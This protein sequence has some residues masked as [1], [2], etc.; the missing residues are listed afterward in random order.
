M[1]YSQ[2]PSRYCARISRTD[3]GP[4]RAAGPADSSQAPL[5]PA[6]WK[7]AR[8]DRA[9]ESSG[10]AARR[11]PLVPAASRAASLPS[12]GW[13]SGSGPHKDG[14]EALKNL[15]RQRWPRRWSPAAPG[16][17]MDPC[18]GPPGLL[19]P[20]LHRSHTHDALR[21]P[22]LPLR[23]HTPG[24]QP[25]STAYGPRRPGLAGGAGPG[26]Q[27]SR[28]SA[29]SWP[30][31]APRGPPRPPSPGL[32]GGRGRAS[33]GAAGGWDAPAPQAPPPPAA[34]PAGPPAAHK[35]LGAAW[36]RG[37]TRG[38]LH[39]TGRTIVTDA[40]ALPS[41]AGRPAAPPPP[42]FPHHYA[43]APPPPPPP[44]PALPSGAASFP[45]PGASRAA[46]SLFPGSPRRRLRAK[47]SGIEGRHVC[48]SPPQ[49]TPRTRL[50]ERRRGDRG[51]VCGPDNMQMN[52]LKIE[53]G[54]NIPSPKAMEKKN[55]KLPKSHMRVPGFN[56]QQWLLTAASC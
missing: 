42:S 33:E 32:L 13:E 21:R 55:V 16:K 15:L 25:T 23:L 41:A 26:G 39:S 24:A 34:G 56:S 29:A 51:V 50:G 4:D 2:K 52:V 17:Q 11:K 27:R 40:L 22:T 38:R 28:D 1:D 14:P 30:G 35:A 12:S 47:G 37:R 9:R 19:Y 43:P 31:Q 45:P 18:L 53:G 7:S 36:S 3:S 8:G 5:G 6:Q 46:S 49:K 10:P 54:E 48:N 44:R 20:A